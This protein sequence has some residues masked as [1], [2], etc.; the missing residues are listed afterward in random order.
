MSAQGYPPDQASALG[1]REQA[2]E[3]REI[4]VG[5]REK[6][7][8]AREASSK[9][10]REKMQLEISELKAQLA[11]AN[12]AAAAAVEMH[13]K[14][15]AAVRVK[16]EHVEELQHAGTC[17]VCFDR[18]ANVVFSPCLHCSTCKTCADALPRAG[19]HNRRQCVIC[20]KD[21]SSTKVFI[22]S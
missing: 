10:D 20:R 16:K 19:A 17:K 12:G 1:L 9:G 18:P 8:L 15:K 5:I 14:T 2:V 11:S 3:S 22:M 6:A 21:V 4:A 7:V 13:Q